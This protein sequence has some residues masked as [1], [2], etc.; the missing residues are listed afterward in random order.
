MHCV[1][2]PG[3]QEVLST[4]LTD[5]GTVWRSNETVY[6]KVPA[7]YKMQVLC[8]GSGVDLDLAVTWLQSQHIRE[9]PQ[10]VT[11]QENTIGIINTE[12]EGK[13]GKNL[14]AM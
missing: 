7:K 8:T 5:G 2:T 14:L 3:A 10:V 13:N 4:R 6:V 9:L 1:G 12:N 11:G